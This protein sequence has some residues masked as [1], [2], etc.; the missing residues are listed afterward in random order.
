MNADIQHGPSTDGLLGCLTQTNGRP[1]DPPGT[2]RLAPCAQCQR[3]IGGE[4]YVAFVLDGEDRL[5]I[6]NLKAPFPGSGWGTA[7]V[8]GLQV[9]Y[10]ER[11]DWTAKQ[12]NESGEIFWTKMAERHQVAI[13]VVHAYDDQG[14]PTTS[15]QPP[16]PCSDR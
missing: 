2:Q 14:R 6:E 12:I 8:R 5:F 16:G 7:L 15:S 9:L 4:A 11:T 10:P 1:W 3:A 13:R